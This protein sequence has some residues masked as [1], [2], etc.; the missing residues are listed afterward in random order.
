MISYLQ[1]SIIEFARQFI[2]KPCP[3]N[4]DIAHGL[5]LDISQVK[6]AVRQLVKN[7]LVTIESHMGGKRSIIFPDGKRTLPTKP[8][9]VRVIRKIET[10]FSAQY[11]PT[12][13]CFYCGAT[14]LHGCQHM[15]IAA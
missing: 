10:D 2:G 4:W 8:K 9:A 5:D 6:S 1:K 3:T 7:E 12:S 11:R 15:R 13:T 14:S